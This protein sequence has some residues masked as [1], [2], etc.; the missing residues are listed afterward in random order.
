VGV[1]GP[2]RHMEE[3]ELEPNDGWDIGLAAGARI[4][5][6]I[7][8]DLDPSVWDYKRTRVLNV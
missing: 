5:Q 8:K 6:S 4:R 3:L 2:L 1:I 7:Y